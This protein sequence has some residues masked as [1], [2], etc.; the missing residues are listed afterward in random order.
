MVSCTIFF[1]YKFL[2]PNTAQ[3][4]SIQETC[5]HVTRMVSSDWL[6]AYR[7]HCF[8]F[9]VLMKKKIL[10][11]FV[12]VIYSPCS[13]SWYA[14]CVVL[15]AI[16]GCIQTFRFRFLLFSFSCA[17][18]AITATAAAAASLSALS[19]VFG[20]KVSCTR[21]C[22]NLH[23]NLMQEA[24]TRN[25]CKFLAQVSWLCFTTITEPNPTQKYHGIPY[26][27]VDYHG[28]LGRYFLPWY[29]VPGY[30]TVYPGTL[31]TMVSSTYVRRPTCPQ[32]PWYF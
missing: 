4:Y 24:C 2:A 17:K 15:F 32:I 23:D 9:V 27:K 26:K 31:Y 5:M 3:L 19:A 16:H 18:T 8:H 22:M 12:P 1:L 10:N 29:N 11:D 6:A 30:A 28:I 14:P 25:L 7:C 21:T 20:M 13:S